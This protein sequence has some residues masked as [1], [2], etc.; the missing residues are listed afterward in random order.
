MFIAAV[1]YRPFSEHGILKFFDQLL[2]L[3]A[4]G[5]ICGI[6]CII[7]DNF[8]SVGVFCC[9]ADFFQIVI[10]RLVRDFINNIRNVYVIEYR[11][12]AVFC[13]ICDKAVFVNPYSSE[14]FIGV[15]KLAR[16]NFGHGAQ[17]VFS[18]GI[19]VNA[20]GF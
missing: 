12:P 3:G 7:T 4:V 9:N 13:E 19:A 16:R 20:N 14:K 18:A 1:A 17:R 6:A 2:T 15:G 8:Y 5:V 11:L 10:G